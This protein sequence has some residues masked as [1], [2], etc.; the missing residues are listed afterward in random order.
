VVAAIAVVSYLEGKPLPA[1]IVRTEPKKHGTRRYIEGVL[2]QRCRAAIVDDVVTTGASLFRAIRAVEE[3]GCQ[4]V[5]VAAL[6]D[7]QQGGSERLRREGYDFTA[8]LTC[9]ESGE[10]LPSPAC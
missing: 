2:P 6:L 1:F 4:V 5:K 10:V 3:E 9:D 7:R 8:L